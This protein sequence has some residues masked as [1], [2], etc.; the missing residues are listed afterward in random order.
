MK[1]LILF[2]TA[3]WCSFLSFGQ[4]ESS[5]GLINETRYDEIKKSPYLFSEFVPAMIYDKDKNMVDEYF[6]NYNGHTEKFEFAYKGDI[7]EL[8]VS[9]YN[10]IVVDSYIPSGD[11]SSRFAS[12][13]ATFVKGLDAQYPDKFMLLVNES[14]DFTVF[15]E[16]DV[17]LYSEETVDNYLKGSFTKLYFTSGFNYYVT[18]NGRK[19]SLK[20]NKK[21]VLQLLNN[22]DVDNFVVTNKLKLNN[23]TE[24]KQVLAL[25]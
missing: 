8:D 6:I 10:K 22:R 24:L 23:E 16:F 9:H 12:E 19:T 17:V 20:L 7:Y 13:S 5:T 15:K 18:Q 14:D 21:N 25:H 4:V 3:S 1:T 11:Y 2:A